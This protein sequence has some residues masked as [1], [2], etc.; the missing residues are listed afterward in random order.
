MKPLLTLIA[1]LLM[2]LVA[3]AQASAP[4]S[5]PADLPG[6][7]A[8]F[9]QTHASKE[10]AL[11]IGGIIT[12]L[13]RLLTLLKP[14]AAKLPPEQTKWLAMGLAMLG[15]AATGLLAHVPWYN[16]VIDGLTSGAAALG[17]W[18]FLLKPLLAKLGASTAPTG[19]VK[20][21]S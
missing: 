18:E 6:I 9:E 11:M 21:A 1:V 17:G 12:V 2:P 13:V 15:S 16:V 14:L 5:L 8:F 10:Y 20:A 3:L 19:P 4:A 7:V